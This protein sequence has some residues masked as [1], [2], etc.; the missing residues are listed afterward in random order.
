MKKHREWNGFTAEFYKLFWADLGVF[1]VRAINF[2]Y[3]IS[4]MSNSQRRSMIIVIS[5]RLCFLKNWRTL[6]L[7]GVDYKIASSAIANRIKNILPK[8]ISATQ[9]GFIKVRK[10][11]DNTRFLSDL[12]ETM[13]DRD[14]EGLLLLIDFEKAFDTLNCEFIDDSLLSFN[15]GP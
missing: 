7:L 10:I 5:R 9:N 8:I 6:F 3:N 12:V 15:F 14:L 2:S 1:L 4:C 11:A 13:D